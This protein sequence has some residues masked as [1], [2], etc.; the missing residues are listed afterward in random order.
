MGLAGQVGR[1]GRE[2]TT[3]VASSPTLGSTQLVS[4]DGGTSPRWAG[5]REIVYR[6][7]RVVS[8]PVTPG[9]TLR[10]GRPTVMFEVD[11]MS[12]QS[13]VS[14]DGTTFVMLRRAGAGTAPAQVNPVLNLFEQLKRIVP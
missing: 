11:D 3:S 14:P 1:E 12:D 6:R 13:D 4:I 2:G 10:L 8:V 5:E 7:G 9:Q